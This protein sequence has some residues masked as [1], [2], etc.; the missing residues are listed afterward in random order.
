LEKDQSELTKLKTKLTN[1]KRE[2]QAKISNTKK[3]QEEEMSQMLFDQEKEIVQKGEEINNLDN[4]CSENQP[5]FHNKI[6][7]EERRAFLEKALAQEAKDLK[8]DLADKEKEKVIETHEL[9]QNI[10][11]KI[12]ETKQALQELKK[13]QLETT[14]R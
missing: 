14:R 2:L 7:T 5:E 12:E 8:R 10:T 4:Q 1:T 11:R 3:A 6:V 9:N 13:E